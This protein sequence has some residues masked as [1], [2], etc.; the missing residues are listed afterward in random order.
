MP[1]LGTEAREDAIYRIVSGP[2]AGTVLHFTGGVGKVLRGP[3]RGT[4]RAI[5]ASHQL[6]ELAPTGRVIRMV[7]AD[8]ADLG[9]QIGELSRSE[10]SLL[11][12]L[13]PRNA[14]TSAI[15]LAHS[16]AQAK[17]PAAQPTLF[18][19]PPQ[20]AAPPDPIKSAEI[21]ETPPNPGQRW[22]DL[23]KGIGASNTAEVLPIDTDTLLNQ[24]G[25]GWP[26]FKEW[27]LAGELDELTRKAVLD[28]PEKQS[29]RVEERPSPFHTATVD[30]GTQRVEA[31]AKTFD[32]IEG[33]ATRARR[34]KKD[35]PDDV[36]RQWLG[37]HFPV[38]AT[39]AFPR[40]KELADSTYRTCGPIITALTPEEL[41]LLD[42]M[43]AWESRPD[44][45]MERHR[46]SIIERLKARRRTLEPKA[47][48]VV[49]AIEPKGA[50]PKTLAELLASTDSEFADV[51]AAIGLA[52]AEEC[53]AALQQLSNG[54][55]WGPVT[56]VLTASLHE[57]Q[58]ALKPPAEVA[59]EPATRELPLYE[60]LAAGDIQLVHTAN[61]DERLNK[62][63]KVILEHND[64]Q[65]AE[66][67]SARMGD[68]MKCGCYLTVNNIARQQRYNR[69]W[70]MQPEEAR[71]EIEG[72]DREA[73]EI[74]LANRERHLHS[75]GILELLRER[76]EVLDTAAKDAEKAWE[77]DA[78]SLASMLPPDRPSEPVGASLEPEPV[79]W[80]MAVPGEDRTVQAVIE[81]STVQTASPMPP[82]PIWNELPQLP[83]RKRAEGESINCRIC[84]KPVDGQDSFH[85]GGDGL[86]F[87][88]DCVTQAVIDGAKAFG[89]EKQAEVDRVGFAYAVLAAKRPAA[90][91]M[92][93]TCE[94]VAWLTCALEVAQEQPRRRKD[95]EKAIEERK[96]QIEGRA[97]LAP[98]PVDGP[99]EHFCPMCRT[100]QGLTP[101]GEK[102][103]QFLL[104]PFGV[105]SFHRMS[106]EEQ[107]AHI[108]VLACPGSS[109]TATEAEW[110]RDQ[111]VKLDFERPDSILQ[112]LVSVDEVEGWLETQVE[113]AT[114][115]LSEQL[116]EEIARSK[117]LLA[118]L[119]QA[120]IHNGAQEEFL[121]K[122]LEITKQEKV[123]DLAEAF[124]VIY[125]TM[126]EALKTIEQQR[127]S[128]ADRDE[129]IGR[130]RRLIEDLEN[131]V[132]KFQGTIE[133]LE[134][135]ARDL[136]YQNQKLHQQLD[137]AQKTT[138]SEPVEPG[139]SHEEVNPELVQLYVLPDQ[140]EAIWYQEPGQ[141]PRYLGQATDEHLRDVARQVRLRMQQAARAQQQTQQK[142]QGEPSLADLL[143]RWGIL[144]GEMALITGKLRASGVPASAKLSMGDA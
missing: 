112:T 129:T 55:P 29:S 89:V 67:V 69:L 48:P 102:A 3:A 28:W 15:M 142:P 136:T 83:I 91:T 94:N 64:T 123:E 122:L 45:P 137:E 41:P 58:A 19:A 82:I 98:A 127:N 30:M 109:M 16:R 128:V 26:E 18:S 71:A 51:Q 20:K 1:I 22:F 81:G 44:I 101:R 72:L 143:A 9:D 24:S 76:L 59:P 132:R 119:T 130:Q 134:T 23:L 21:E 60:A 36:M 140:T 32:H 74:V 144:A 75:H 10:Q 42:V 125:R 65:A 47:L 116:N 120:A 115:E 80:D 17:P 141:T 4:K 49:N 113:E 88:A 73:L 2:G 99:P 114:G 78:P 97:P 96:A 79:Q 54:S 105:Q 126:Q 100:L 52:T 13:D 33:A 14:I 90:S 25:G 135:T 27:L 50:T 11:T 110:A 107:G 131:D 68:V 117:D 124:D 103:W 66:A 53:E 70:H 118:K 108:D 12:D 5:D 40:L 77:D 85:D 46:V 138:S 6:E 63:L 86:Q 8:I 62:A 139:Q 104:H 56:G 95:I 121:L 39:M 43:V 38:R 37:Q 111:I 93:R 57:R 7:G 31:D 106:E 87:C 84:L 133:D 34:K 35:D 61:D 92:I